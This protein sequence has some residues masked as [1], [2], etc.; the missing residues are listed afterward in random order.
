M[1]VGVRVRAM[2]SSTTATTRRVKS[3]RIIP[4]RPVQAAAE[5]IRPPRR[6]AV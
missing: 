3:R 1:I 6:I 5:S 4:K 2:S